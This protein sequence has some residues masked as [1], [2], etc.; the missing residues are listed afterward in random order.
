LC[1]RYSLDRYRQLQVVL[2]FRSAAWCR[3]FPTISWI[4]FESLRNSIKAFWNSECEFV[5]L[6][7]AVQSQPIAIRREKTTRL[8]GETRVAAKRQTD[9]IRRM[10]AR[11]KSERKTAPRAFE[12]K[13]ETGRRQNDQRPSGKIA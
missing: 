5:E 12:T 10:L 11:F 13:N 8:L 4:S 9:R 2:R 3:K 6:N 7:E 1:E